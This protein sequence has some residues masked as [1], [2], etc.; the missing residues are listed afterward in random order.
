MSIS[1]QGIYDDIAGEMGVGL[2][3]EKLQERVL[4]AVNRTLAVLSKK[5]NDTSDLTQVTKI[6]AFITDVDVDL[7]FV[8]WAG[9]RFFMARSG[10]RPADPR[11]AEVVYRDSKAEWEEAIG[12][13]ITSVSND[14]QADSDDNDIWSWGT[15]VDDS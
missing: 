2:G 4:R 5:T 9:V 1:V 3:S 8:I 12:D 7:E 10:S 13:Y 14:D 6:G 15:D 11:I